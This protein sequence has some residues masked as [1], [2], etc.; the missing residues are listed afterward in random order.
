MVPLISITL[1]TLI[2]HNLTQGS[3]SMINPICFNI[4]SFLFMG[5][6]NHIPSC[7]S[8]SYF[9]GIHLLLDSNFKGWCLEFHE[10]VGGGCKLKFMI[11]AEPSPQLLIANF[12]PL[13]S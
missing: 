2:Y 3:P 13:D 6:T 1:F 10:V 12:P 7:T 9:L 11:S 4:Q 8:S 5:R